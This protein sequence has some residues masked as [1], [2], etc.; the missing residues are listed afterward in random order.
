MTLAEL[1][2]LPERKRDAMIERL[3]FKTKLCRHSKDEH[4]KCSKCGL[5]ESH[6]EEIE[7]PRHFSHPAHDYAVLTHVRETWDRKAPAAGGKPPRYG[8]FFWGLRDLWFDRR[9]PGN[10]VPSCH[11]TWEPDQYRPGDYSIVA[12]ASLE[13]Q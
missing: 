1:L 2:A 7:P 9:W 10:T 12:L 13:N 11:R 3:V 5:N 4:G 6:W 8:S